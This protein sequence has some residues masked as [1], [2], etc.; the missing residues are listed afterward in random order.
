MKKVIIQIT[1]GRGPVECSRVVA[2][3]QEL[4]MKQ[5]KDQSINISVLES[6][7]GDLKGTML[8][9]TL[10]AEG[11]NV[12][13]LR[14]F[15]GTIQWI[16]KSPYRPMHKRKNW[17]VGVSFFEMNNQ[18]SFNIKDVTITTA[19]SGGSGGQNVNKVETAVRA[20]HEPTGIQ[21]LATDS[22]SQLENK[23]LAIKRLEEKVLVEKTKILAEQQQD[24][25][26]EHNILERGNP[27]KTFEIDLR[28]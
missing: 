17:F 8:S 20:R 21:V 24:K 10:L 13:I 3:V 19:R 9:T 18:L 25:W 27:T 7:K 23:T 22:R 2:K 26:Q 6:T 14:E 11:K 1:S 4:V 16:S 15:E 5:A 28:K 12:D